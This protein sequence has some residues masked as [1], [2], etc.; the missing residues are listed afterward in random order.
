[1]A[2]TP[3]YSQS[4]HV[5]GT[6]WQYSLTQ[7]RITVNLE[8]KLLG[9]SPR[10]DILLLRREGEAWNEAQRARLPDGLRDNAAGHVLVEFK[11]SESVNESALAQAVAYDHFYRQG[12]R[13]SEEEVMTVLL[14]ARTPRKD[15]LEM[16][17]YEEV[18][19]GVY[20]SPLPLLRRVWLLALNR[21][22]AKPHNAYVKF[23]ASRMQEREAAFVALAESGVVES[24]EL[25]SYILGLQTTMEAKGENEM[26]EPLTPEKIMEIGEKVRDYVLKTT[27]EPESVNETLR[28]RILEVASPQE[29]L[30]GLDPQEKL[31]G[32]DPEERLAGLDPEER[33]AGMNAAERKALLRRLQDEVDAD[34]RDGTDNNG[35][36]I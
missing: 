31:A 30:A 2:P 14:S 25:Q 35:D 4:H 27:T 22:E 1:M 33:L 32:L 17:G 16:W 8:P 6:L 12:Q 19:K 3:L 5:L 24:H 29:K 10:A 36:G 23:F 9:D 28:Q 11:Y 7:V 15:R 21:L 20:L 13:L 26:T 18:Q 34:A